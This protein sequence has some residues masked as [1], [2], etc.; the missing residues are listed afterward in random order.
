MRHVRQQCPQNS[1]VSLSRFARPPD[2]DIGC[3]PRPSRITSPVV[4]HRKVTVW[5]APG[6]FAEFASCWPHGG[7]CKRYSPVC[8]ALRKA[9]AESSGVNAQCLHSREFQ[10][11]VQRGV[12]RLERFSLRFAIASANGKFH[13]RSGPRVFP[14]ETEAPR[15]TKHPRV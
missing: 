8:G 14:V 9:R 5:L 6:S 13:G 10:I 3:H 11:G 12:R 1:P 7:S 4:A 15:Q 2:G